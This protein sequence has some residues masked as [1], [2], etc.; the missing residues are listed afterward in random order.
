MRKV[1]RIINNP[2][3]F[4]IYE[5]SGETPGCFAIYPEEIRKMEEIRNA[6]IN[7]TIPENYII[8]AYRFGKCCEKDPQTEIRDI[9]DKESVECKVKDIISKDIGYK[10]CY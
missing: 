1:K 7:Q 3:A 10:Y 6:F 8:K 2:G 9:T 5:C 4:T